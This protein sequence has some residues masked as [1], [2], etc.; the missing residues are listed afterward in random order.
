[1]SEPTRKT[2]KQHGFVHAH[3]NGPAERFM[4]YGASDGPASFGIRVTARYIGTASRD[5]RTERKST[6]IAL[7]NID[8]IQLFT[9]SPNAKFWAT[10]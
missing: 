10:P 9:L 1:M 6:R 3:A 8:G 2:F 5:W 7:D 4:Y